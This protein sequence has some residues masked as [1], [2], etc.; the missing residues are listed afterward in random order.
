MT[1][2]NLRR[3]NDPRAK[4]VFYSQ[5]D[6]GCVDGYEG[7]LSVRQVKRDKQPEKWGKRETRL[8]WRVRRSTLE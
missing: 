8:I 7:H 5:F 4:S 2:L 6:T 1:T 3:I